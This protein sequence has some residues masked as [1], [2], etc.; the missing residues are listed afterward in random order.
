MSTARPS[1]MR[2]FRDEALDI[3][4]RGLI[5]TERMYADLEHGRRYESLIEGIDAVASEADECSVEIADVQR[6][7]LA[8]RALCNADGL[9]PLLQKTDVVYDAAWRTA[10]EAIH[11]ASAARKLLM[12]L[13]EML[14]EE[15]EDDVPD[16]DD[17]DD[18]EG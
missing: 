18:A 15:D 17:A 8:L 2:F 12:Q 1:A 11:T 7:V 13:R 4:V 10:I 3:G 14:N 6:G 16:S 5:D 9:I